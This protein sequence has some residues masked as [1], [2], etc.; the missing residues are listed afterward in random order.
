MTDFNS[1]LQYG[2]SASLMCVLLIINTFQLFYHRY[3]G[4][5]STFLPTT[6]QSLNIFCSIF[7]LISHWTR[8]FLSSFTGFCVF[9]ILS[10]I[11]SIGI[12]SNANAAVY[13]TTRNAYLAMYLHSQTMPV[14]PWLAIICVT[15]LSFVISCIFR[16]I[17]NRNIFYV[18]FLLGN[19]LH[20]IFLAIVGWY[21]F[22]KLTTKLEQQTTVS[23]SPTRLVAYRRF[24]IITTVLVGLV[25][26]ANFYQISDVMRRNEPFYT[27][28][29]SNTFH[30][31]FFLI[32]IQIAMWY[33]TYWSA[34]ANSMARERTANDHESR[35]RSGSGISTRPK[36]SRA[37]SNSN[38]GAL[39][40]P[41]TS[42]VS[43]VE[44]PSEAAAEPVSKPAPGVE[45]EV[46]E[47]TDIE[48]QPR[49]Q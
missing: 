6:L 24:L 10:G 13:E 26:V 17:L 29:D 21:F 39:K 1:Q 43:V 42:P 11:G 49:A 8:C 15:S 14:W 47:L 3:L 7:Y 31:D 30:F 45:L 4:C 36:H 41:S 23:S 20:W 40:S 34:Q 37:A 44:E 16:M 22:L 27:E 33:T 35:H 38:Y 25:I 18:I 9:Y 48:A 2:I 19:V 32:L 46:V 28:A 5:P 12:L